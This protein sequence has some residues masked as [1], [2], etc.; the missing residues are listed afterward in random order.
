MSELKDILNVL[1]DTK[2]RISTVILCNPK[3]KEILE[4]AGINRNNV[5]LIEDCHIELNQVVIVEDLEMK[6]MLIS[7]FKRKEQQNETNN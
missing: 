7:N 4:K 6:K 3:Q 1:E 2:A 5:Y